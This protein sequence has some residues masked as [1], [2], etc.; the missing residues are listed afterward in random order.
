MSL[1]S[2][3]YLY[4]KSLDKNKAQTETGPKDQLDLRCLIPTAA[5]GAIIGRGGSVIK[6]IGE[7]NSCHLNLERDTGPGGHRDSYNTK[8]RALTIKSN[9][10]VNIAN[11]RTLYLR[12]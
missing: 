7:K 6:D 8:E 12:Q 1:E 5:S 9:A 10:V 2:T 3:S 11:V 4:L